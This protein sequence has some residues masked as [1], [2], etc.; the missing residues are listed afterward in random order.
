MNFWRG[1]AN[2]AIVVGLWGEQRECI[3][4]SGCLYT[5]WGGK[6]DFFHAFGDVR[7]F[8]MEIYNRWGKVAYRTNNILEGWDGKAKGL[9]QL[10]GAYIYGLY[11]DIDRA[12]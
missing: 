5:H 4:V 8:E 3:I 1:L 10:S 6:N 2:L 11:T 12:L 7:N 9:L